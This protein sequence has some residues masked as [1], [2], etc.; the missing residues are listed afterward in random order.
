[1]SDPGRGNYFAW[2]WVTTEPLQIRSKV[3]AGSFTAWLD[4]VVPN[5]PVD[6]TSLAS[7]MTAIDDA[8]NTALLT[9]PFDWALRYLSP[10]RP[11]WVRITPL[12]PSLPLEIELTAALARVL[13]TPTAFTIGAFSEYETP[14]N[15]LN[16]WQPYA[17]VADDDDY[18][19]A[20][21]LAY[22]SDL[23]GSGTVFASSRHDDGVRRY[24]RKWRIPAIHSARIK[25]I[26]ATK[27]R[28]MAE[29][30]GLTA[31]DFIARPWTA[32]DAQSGLANATADGGL[33]FRYVERIGDTLG[34]GLESAFY[35]VSYDESAPLPMDGWRGL[36]APVVTPYGAIGGTSTLTMCALLDDTLPNTWGPA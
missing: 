12:A 35:R 9:M 26:R 16:H 13:G 17:Y 30:A 6:R 10:E 34:T 7:V 11:V 27:A 19:V 20:D 21:A 29:V 3:G 2:P 31:A 15:P 8:Y 36:R 1:M 22:T 25:Y 14:H 18:D 23:A 33:P 32:L 28:W 24:W 4:V 5:N